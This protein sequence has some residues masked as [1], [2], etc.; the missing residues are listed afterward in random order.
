MTKNAE[1]E[2]EMITGGAQSEYGRL[3]QRNMKDYEAKDM[4]KKRWQGSPLDLIIEILVTFY[5]HVANKGATHVLLQE[6]LVA[7]GSSMVKSKKHG[8]IF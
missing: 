4:V 5:S 1:E 6:S 7:L 2:A 3:T 8:S